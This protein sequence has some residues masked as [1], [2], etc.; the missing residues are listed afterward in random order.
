MRLANAVRRRRVRR[1]A[2][3]V[4]EAIEN[5]DGDPVK[6]ETELRSKITSIPVLVELG[7]ILLKLLLDY[8]INHRR[9]ERTAVIELLST[10]AVLES[11]EMYMIAEDLQDEGM[12][13]LAKSV[14]WMAMNSDQ[15]ND[16]ETFG[17]QEIKE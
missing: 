13:S 6:A 10:A 8:W 15:L 9:D 5:N 16:P 4:W 11:E 14:R 17:E 12:G 7:L 1:F 2:R 3:V